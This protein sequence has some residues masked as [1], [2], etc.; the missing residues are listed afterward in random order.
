MSQKSM[1]SM[2]ENMFQL[3][4]I[5][6]NI[7]THRLTDN[8]ITSNQITQFYTKFAKWWSVFTV[9]QALKHMLEKPDQTPL[10][11]YSEVN[12]QVLQLIQIIQANTL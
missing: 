1:D 12:S 5:C 4:D 2:P 9:K 7:S 3:E 10:I 8:I 6:E 11:V